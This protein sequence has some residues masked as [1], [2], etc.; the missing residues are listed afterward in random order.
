MGKMF[1]DILGKEAEPTPQT[2]KGTEDWSRD[3]ESKAKALEG[4]G[5]GFTTGMN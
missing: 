3:V 1:D 5:D 2:G 4:S